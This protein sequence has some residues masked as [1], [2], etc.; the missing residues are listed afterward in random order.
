MHNFHASWLPAVGMALG[1]QR[2][3]TQMLL[4]QLLV[5]SRS[6]KL[7]NSLPAVKQVQVLWF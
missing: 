7:D 2:H 4:S 3:S 5:L 1:S 6:L